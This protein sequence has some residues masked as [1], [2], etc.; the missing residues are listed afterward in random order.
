MTATI[1]LY[2]P[3]T[4]VAGPPHEWFA[5]MRRAEP[6]YWQEIPRQPGYW[7]LLK[8]TDCVHVAKHPLLFSAE[9]GGVVL[10]T[11][12]D[13]MLTMMRGQLLAMD[14]PRHVDYRRPLAP[15]FKAKVIA[16]LEPQ[17]RDVCRRIMAEAKSVGELDYVKLTSTLPSQ[18]V[19]VLMG[20]P[21]ADWSHIHHLAQMITSG[22]DPDIN[23]DGPAYGNSGSNASGEMAEYAMALAARRRQEAPREDLTTVL[24]ETEFGGRFMDDLDFGK[25]F[26]QLVTAGND[27][28][29]TL[30]SSGLLLL[31]RHPEQLA[32]MRADRDLIPG[33]VEEMLRVENPLHYFRRTATADTVI[34]GPAIKEGDKVAMYYTSA[35]RDEDVFAD[36]QRFDI[37]RNPNPH[38]SFGIS[39]HF[40]LGVHLARLEARAFF[41]ELLRTFSTIE[42]TGQVTRTRSNLNTALK[43]MP[44]RLC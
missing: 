28:T 33:A 6:V 37:T 34:N 40:C 42:L 7:A 5:E 2:D 12:P 27:T 19:G 10:E 44:G 32:A 35:N 41:E 38:L 18:V 24:L 9:T 1:D 21:R 39:E 8:H 31:L 13:A 17:I 4:Y 11:L 30:L 23:P 20:L 36:P 16:G 14:P 43:S 29:R 26:V 25:F 22:S 3:D 15:Y